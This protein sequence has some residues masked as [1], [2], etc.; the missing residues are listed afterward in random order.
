MSLFIN[1]ATVLPMSSFINPATVL[2]MSSFINNSN[3]VH[4]KVYLIQHYVIKFVS[5]FLW[6]LCFPPPI[7][8]NAT[9][10]V[11][12]WVGDIFNEVKS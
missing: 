8:L 2:L 11:A 3:L 12:K 10:L 5:G 4:G 1:P 6:L 7:K 9:L